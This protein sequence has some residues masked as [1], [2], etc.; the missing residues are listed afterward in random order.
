MLAL[1]RTCAQPLALTA[2]AMFAVGNGAIG[3]HAHPDEGVSVIV[4]HDASAHRFDDAAR[5]VQAHPEYCLACGWRRSL[6]HRSDAYATVVSA[7]DGGTLL[8]VPAA[9]ARAS[10]A[11][12]AQPPLRAPP[13]SP[14]AA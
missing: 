1:F 10:A 14:A 6:R 7:D 11:L 4:E 8:R 9:T 5:H 2:L 3:L 13:D 12:A